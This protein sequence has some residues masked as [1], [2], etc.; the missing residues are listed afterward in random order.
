ME[1]P[2]SANHQRF[3]HTNIFFPLNIK[4]KKKSEVL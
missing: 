3:T 1:D 2:L 4:E